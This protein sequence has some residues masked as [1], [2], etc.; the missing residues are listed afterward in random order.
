MRII[1]HKEGVLRRFVMMVTALAASLPWEA[2]VFAVLA[3]GLAVSAAVS[4]T[5]LYV[6]GG[7]MLVLACFVA[8]DRLDL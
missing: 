3:A 2:R 1:V 4:V 6:C 7:G 5:G 8:I